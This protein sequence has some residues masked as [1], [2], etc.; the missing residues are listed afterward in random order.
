MAVKIIKIALWNANG[1]LNHKN[2]VEVFLKT[3]S[4]D[5]LLISETHFTDKTYFKI[6]YYNFY[7]TYHPDGK[8][9]GG[10][11]ILIKNNIIHHELARFSEH[12]I[13]ATSILIKTFM[14][15]IVVSAVYCPPK[16]NINRHQFQEYFSTLGHKF[17]AGGDYNSKHTAFG[18]RLSTTKGKQLHQL[19][20]DNNYDIHSTGSPTYW[21]SDPQKKPDMLDFFISNGTSAIQS[22]V[23]PNYEIFSDH[24]PII[25]TLSSVQIYS[26]G[27]SSLHNMYTNWNEYKNLLSNNINLKTKLKTHADLEQALEYFINIMTETVQKVTPVNINKEKHSYVPSEIKY[28]ISKKKQIRKEWQKSHH[29]QI[30]T[31]LNKITKTLKIKIK[32]WKQDSFKNYVMGLNRYDQ[33]IWRPIKN[34][35]KP[36]QINAPLKT[37]ASTSPWIRNEKEKAAYFAEHLACTFSL[38]TVN[39]SEEEIK[40]ATQ[41]LPGTNAKI[42]PVTPKELLSIIKTLKIKKSPGP[43][44]ITAKMLKE[45]PIK[46]IIFLTHLTNAIFKLNYWPE[47]LKSAEIIV[48]LKQGKDPTNVDSYRPISILSIIAKII[49][50][51]IL[52]RL[53]EDSCSINWIPNH[54]FG[55]RQGHTTTQQ[56][57]R[58]IDVILTTLN[59]KKYAVAAFLDASK[60]FDKVWHPGLL[61]KIKKNFPLF[62]NLLQSYLT[63]RRFYVKLK[64]EISSEFRIKS[65]VPQGSVLSPFLYNLYTSDIPLSTSTTICTFA[66]DI[67]LVASDIDQQTANKYLQNHLVKLKDW[68]SNWKISINEKKSA[69]IIFTLRHLQD[70]PLYLNGIEI[71]RNNSVKYLGFHL[72]QKLN[73]N[74]HISKKISQVKLKVKEL[75]W[76]IGR[77]SYLTIDNKLLLYKTIIIPIWTYGIE[78]WGCASKSSISKL[79]RALNKILRNLVNAPWYVSNHTIHKD[80]KLP[81]IQE[82]IIT[83]SSAYQDKIFSHSNTLMND[84]AMKQP[85]RRL[86]RKWPRD[87]AA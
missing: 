30:K 83:R 36:V 19:I 27:R 79:Q 26:S 64:H 58:V 33:S 69:H 13:Q 72:D 71:P 34:K 57:N 52:Q 48:I 68:F 17:I 77:S 8:S 40:N 76:L 84:I 22:S 28:L 5:I 42:K 50:K 61:Y 51:V 1:L 3:N 15:D 38:P 21:P 32:M 41:L 16:H 87:L 86:K 53:E 11:A 56:T 55:F 67:A 7:H 39:S 63:D 85:I 35:R 31:D 82:L 62:F 12:H 44:R 29:P 25:L 74:Q 59:K 24:T 46:C 73:W 54:Q 47:K 18:S 80:L 9:H 2:E 20:V 6:P 66:D 75:D 65:G 4:I 81:T 78:L 43:D 45:L 70:M 60:A 23:E 37:N 14:F 49:E 10:T